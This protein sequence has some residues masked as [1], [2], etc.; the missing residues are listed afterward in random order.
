MVSESGVFATLEDKVRWEAEPLSSR[1]SARSLYEQLSQTA[2]SF[3]RRP[4]LSFQITSGPTDKAITL[5]WAELRA[6]VA[7]AANLFRELGVDEGDAV[8]YLLPNCNESPFANL[9]RD[10]S[11]ALKP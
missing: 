6:E 4:A 8:A 9:H 2:S 10:L 7:R 5:S 11:L 3:P 1:W